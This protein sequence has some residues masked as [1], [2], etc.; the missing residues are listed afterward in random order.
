[1]RR[2]KTASGATAVQIVHKRGRR[3][4][5][6]EHIGSAHTDDELAVLLQVAEERRHAGQL[7][8]DFDGAGAGGAGTLA[9]VEGTASLILWEV[10]AGIYDDLGLDRLGDGA[11]RALVLARVIEPASK[12]DT[13]RV[14]TEIGVASPHRVTFMRCLKRVVERDYRAVI[15]QACHR[16][17]TLAASLAVVLYDVTSLH[18]E[19]EREDKLRRVGVSKE[20]R[21]DPQVTVGLLTTATGFPLEVDLFE[22]NKAET[23]TLIPVLTRFRDRYQAH[24]IVVVADAGMLSA[25]NLLALEDS[26]F[27]FIVGS[28]AGKI[29]YELDA[30]V[31]RHGNYLA[32]GATI[33]T[34]R[35]MGSGKK[36]RD[37]RVVYHYA[38]KR[39]QH[40]NK[41]INAMVERAEKVASG[42]RPLKKDRFVTFTDTS[43]SVNWDLVERARSLAG[44]KGYVTNIDPAAMDGPAV[45]AAYHDLYQ[46]E[47]SFRMTKS[48]L[49]ARP[50]FHRLED[51]IQAHLTIVFAALA[52]S[53]EAQTR[54][55]LSINR[56]LKVLRPLR[57]ATVTIGAQHVT[58]QPR[59]PA[60]ARTLLNDLGWSG[61]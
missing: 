40:D 41:A 5:S 57:S 16:H 43:T 54:A 26:G 15:A 12:L 56:I 52:V 35:R 18:F 48:D 11:F 42:E 14:L 30:H 27:R 22:G 2:V 29:P 51:S 3:V 37:R 31:E 25:A 61:H 20:H 39:A 19:V 60:E 58:A 9:V 8:L 10:L 46:V 24:D 36:A 38:F 44:I 47:R 17:A 50:V 7:A 23:K 53:R 59:I 33:E 32:D 21:V 49:A 55:G 45:V 34:T 1:V 28:R 4:L 13:V 6:I